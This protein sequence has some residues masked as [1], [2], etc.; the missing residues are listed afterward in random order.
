MADRKSAAQ[1]KKMDDNTRRVDGRMRRYL[2]ELMAGWEYGW[3]HQQKWWQ[4]VKMFVSTS[5]IG[6]R[7]RICMA[8]QAEWWQDETMYGSTSRIDGRMR[9]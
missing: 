6:G 9:R 4:D 8:A 2:A 7:M 1:Y 3:Q 5:R